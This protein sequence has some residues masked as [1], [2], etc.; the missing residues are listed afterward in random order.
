MSVGELIRLFKPAETDEEK[1][2][3]GFILEDDTRVLDDITQ[4]ADEGQDESLSDDTDITTTV[5]S[6]DMD[7]DTD[8][9]GDDSDTD[10]KVLA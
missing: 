3:G 10:Y 7:S 8:G 2:A 9:S 4:P 6:A 1:E 5:S